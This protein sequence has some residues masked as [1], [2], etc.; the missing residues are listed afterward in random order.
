[1]LVKCV[2]LARTLAVFQPRDSYKSVHRRV[3][4]VIELLNELVEIGVCQD[5]YLL[6]LSCRSDYILADIWADVGDNVP[7]M[8]QLITIKNTNIKSLGY[9]DKHLI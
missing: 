9:S 3:E 7:Q 1:M 5:T 2:D 8:N 6:D 4:L